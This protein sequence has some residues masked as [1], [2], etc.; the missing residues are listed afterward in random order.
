MAEVRKAESSGGKY[1]RYI[2]AGRPV[3]TRAMSAKD[4]KN[5]GIKDQKGVEWN[6]RNNYLVPAEQLSEDAIQHLLR[7][8]KEFEQTDNN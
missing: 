7:F 4:W 6:K 3:T 8:P 5:A 1:V 2:P